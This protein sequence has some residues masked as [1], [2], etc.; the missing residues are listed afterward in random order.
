LAPFRTA[1]HLRY[2]LSSLCRTIID[3]TKTA[4]AIQ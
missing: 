3:S 2:V 1:L 4:P